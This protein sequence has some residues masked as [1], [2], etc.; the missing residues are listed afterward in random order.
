MYFLLYVFVVVVV[1]NGF[2]L[3]VC[4][5]FTLDCENDVRQKQILVIFLSEFKMGKAAKRVH[6]IN[7]ALGPGTANEHIVVQEA[8]PRR[9]GLADEKHL[10]A[11]RSRQQAVGSSL[12]SWSAKDHTRSRQKLSASLSRDIRHLPQTGKVKRLS[13]QGLAS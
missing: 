9:R 4:F 5:I 1:V 12:P 6:N 8:L 11:I 2:L 3:S 7:N 13:D 10:L